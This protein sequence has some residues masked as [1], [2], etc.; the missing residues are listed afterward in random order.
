MKDDLN[1]EEIT[2]LRERYDSLILTVFRTAT[3]QELLEKWREI[4]V[5]NDLFAET[6]REQCYN[7]GQRDFV[8]EILAK[9]KED[10]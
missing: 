9:F 3:G 5:E 8:L 1:Q 7:I 4:F 2:Q 6:D 10:S